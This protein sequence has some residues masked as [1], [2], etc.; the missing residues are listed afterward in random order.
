[1]KKKKKE[2]ID[3]KLY[4]Q[5]KIMLVTFVIIGI[6]MVSAILLSATVKK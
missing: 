1:M 4:K 2:V 5:S 6:I 3:E